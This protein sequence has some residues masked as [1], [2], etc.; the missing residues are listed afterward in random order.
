MDEAQ[1]TP[2]QLG[3]V[4]ALSPR[5][6]VLIEAGMTREQIMDNLVAV[7]G[8]P[9]CA[10]KASMERVTQADPTQSKSSQK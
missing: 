5:I 3:I 4:N 10:V 1:L 6:Q 2:N 9:I 7:E 8:W